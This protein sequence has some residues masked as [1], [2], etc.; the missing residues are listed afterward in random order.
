MGISRTPLPS[1]EL[2][3]RDEGIRGAEARRGWGWEG[4]CSSPPRPPPPVPVCIELRRRGATREMLATGGGACWADALADGSGDELP[5]PGD[6]VVSV[7]DPAVDR[8]AP[9]LTRSP[10]LPPVLPLVPPAPEEAGSA[11]PFA[12]D[13]RAAHRSRS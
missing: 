5:T 7:L 9:E 6:S 1:M 3:R 11:P 8:V 10:S 4:G 13:A 12:L 2:R